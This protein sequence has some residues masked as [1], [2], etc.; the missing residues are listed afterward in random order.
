MQK[1]LTLSIVIPAY[2]EEGHIQA[3]LEA[4]ARQSVMPDEVIVVDNNSSDKT[5]TLARQ[6]KFVRILREENQGIIFARNAGFNAATSD[7][8]G[9][10]DAD[11]ILPANWVRYVK[12]FYSKTDHKNHALTGNG[13]FYNVSFPPEPINGWVQ[14]QIVFRVNRFLLG[15]YI[16][17]GSN[18]AL[19]N[20]A[21][22]A[23]R[24]KVCLRNDIHEDLDLAIHLHR[25]GYQITY[26]ENLRVEL[27]M[28]RIF[29]NRKALYGNLMMWPRTVRTHGRWTWIFGWLGA[30]FLWIGSFFLL[31]ERRTKK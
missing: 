29:K 28:K 23:V 12:D 22:K 13:V 30:I 15:H 9:R 5:A 8:I 19:P 2:N 18:M 21:W 27:E 14:G 24:D 11:T 25:H 4:I 16:L 7:I 1:A 6:F 17:W 3:C 26:K 31:P 10:I 20:T